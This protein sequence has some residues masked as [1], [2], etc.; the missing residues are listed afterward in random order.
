MQFL[1]FFITSVISFSGLVAGFYLLKIAPEEQ[2]PLHKYLRIFR[3]LLVAGIL[4]LGFFLPKNAISLLPFLVLVLLS[5]YFIIRENE[6]SQ[7]LNSAI[8]GAILCLASSEKRILAIAS[9]FIFLFFLA[10]CLI[11]ANIKKK[12]IL[13]IAFNN[14]LFLVSSNIIYLTIFHS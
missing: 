7:S 2:K 9:V 8:L 13:K 12:N 14:S 5:I 1:N 6:K 11:S 4:V 10:T 3:Y